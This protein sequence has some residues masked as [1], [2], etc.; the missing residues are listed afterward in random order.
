MVRLIFLLLFLKELIPLWIYPGWLR[1]FIRADVVKRGGAEREILI[2]EG[3]A[4]CYFCLRWVLVGACWFLV[5][6]RII[7]R[8]AFGWYW[9]PAESAEQTRAL[10]QLLNTNDGPTRL[11]QCLRHVLALCRTRSGER[12][13][14]F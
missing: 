4:F 3:A 10:A 9:S 5:F 7:G 13:G 11:H 12:E 1:T 14:N 2:V 8:Y 6:R